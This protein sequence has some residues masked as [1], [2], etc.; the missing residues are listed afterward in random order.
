MAVQ[1]RSGA[2]LRRALT[3]LRKPDGLPILVDIYDVEG[4]RIHDYQ[5]RV[6]ARPG[7]LRLNGPVLGPRGRPLYQDHSFYPLTDFQTAGAVDGDW[8]ATWGRG[9]QSVRATVLTPCSEL[10]T[11]R[12]PGWRSQFEITADPGRALDTVVLRSRRKRSRF[13]VVYE[14][15]GGAATVRS[16]SV[17]DEG[18]SVCVV[19]DMVGRN[20][21]EVC[22]PGDIAKGSESRWQVGR[23]R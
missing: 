16:A 21:I 2:T 11:Y 13:V 1:L 4:G 20:R 23:S 5:T 3:L 22:T 19:L 8:A 12:S 17:R 14:V 7:Q 6:A 15:L 10:I 18:E 9:R